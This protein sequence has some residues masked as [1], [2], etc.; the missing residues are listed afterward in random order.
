M[1]LN[2]YFADQWTTN[3]SNEQRLVEGLIVE[4]IQITGIEVYYLP[5]TFVKEDQL[6]GEDVLSKFE[7][8]IPVEVYFKNITGFG[9]DKE[10]ISKFGL[11]I[12]DRATFIVARIRWEQAI[13]RKGV[14][15]LNRPAEG[16]LIYLPKTNSLFEI[17]FTKLEDPF[18]Q[19]GKLYVYEMEC[20]L[21]AYSSEKI[22]TG[23]DEIDT[24]VDLNSLA[25]DDH[26]LYLEDGTRFILEGSGDPVALFMEEYTL[27]EALPGADNE[28]IRIQGEVV[29]DWSEDN[30]FGS[31]ED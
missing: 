18:Y 16:D 28:F 21:F 10:F 14:A 26:V 2:Y 24:V 3:N 20:E 27:D 6:F 5:R 25:D 30:P 12:R 7:Y 8:A 22:E 15:N 11:E 23:V 17:K 19:L 4:S 9:G 13:K 31:V 29:V 1:P